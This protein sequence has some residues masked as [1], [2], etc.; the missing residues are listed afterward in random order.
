MTPSATAWI[1]LVAL[2]LVMGALIFGAA[3]VPWF[4][5]G[6]LFLAIFARLGADYPILIASDPALLRRRCEAGPTAEKEPTQR[7]IMAIQPLRPSSP[8]RVVPGLDRRFGWS[9]RAPGRRVRR[10]RASSQLG[11]FIVFLVFRA[12]QPSRRR[13]SRLSP[14]Q[15]VVSTGPYA[16]RP[17]SPCTPAP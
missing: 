10:R 11:F 3:G 12:E 16:D 2:A 5:Q 14:G 4:R 15:R 13:R 17:A 8:C 1:W 9:Q 7:L 6:W